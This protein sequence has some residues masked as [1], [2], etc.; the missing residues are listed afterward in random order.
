MK[1]VSIYSL[2]SKI[3]RLSKT[4]SQRQRNKENIR[5][6][7]QQ[8]YDIAVMQGKTF[9]ATEYA[10]K[11]KG[12]RKKGVL[13][14]KKDL[15]QVLRRDRKY[16]ANFTPRKQFEKTLRG[17]FTNATG[18]RIYQD[19]KYK[20]LEG[21]D[22]ETIKKA[23]VEDQL[24]LIIGDPN[25]K[26]SLAIFKY[27]S[28]ETEVARELNK[29]KELMLQDKDV[30]VNFGQLLQYTYEKVIY[31]KYQDIKQ[32]ELYDTSTYEADSNFFIDV[33]K[34]MRISYKRLMQGK[35]IL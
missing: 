21:K 23:V 15:G 12:S 34:E 33:A 7:E 4:R 25:D 16:L 30:V 13:Q 14:V 11:I 5:E 35:N 17:Y 24:D 19:E 2:Q 20:H 27:Q 3:R 26:F 31:E 9:V 28:G 29:L 32:S 22:I 1:Q 8:I 18:K 10:T 6:L